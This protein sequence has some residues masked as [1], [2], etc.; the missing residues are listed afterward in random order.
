MNIN[1][2]MNEERTM[3]AVETLSSKQ[4]QLIGVGAAMAAGCEPCTV[5]FVA[6]AKAEG[7]CERGVRFAIESG[8]QGRASATASMAAFA[9]AAFPRP[10]LDAT[11]REE[12]VLLDALIGVAAA[13]A[14]SAAPV[15]TS[16]VDEARALGATDDQLRVAAQIG[17]A[18][19]RGAE[20]ETESRFGALLESGSGPRCCAGSA[21]TDATGAEVAR[22]SPTRL[23]GGGRPP[24]PCGCGAP[25]ETDYE[26]VSIEKTHAACSLCEDYARA[27]S[28]KPVVVMS[29]E[30]ACLRGEISRQAANH[31][32]HSLAPDTTVR[33]CLGGAFTKDA[34]QRGLVRNAA[35]VVALEGCS[36]RCASR[37]MRGHFPHL[38]AEVLVTDGM[39]NFDRSLF[40]IEA[41]PEET[42][43]ELGRSVAA[44]VAG[45]L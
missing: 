31:L 41:L 33:L 37:M 11:F 36:I 38:E 7:A 24:G 30:G 10:E 23:E 26:T 14:S 17:R 35:K 44:K 12:R 13:V 4:K 28:H 25:D 32:C 40:G 20:G 18:A 19:R 16:R 15:L 29:C 1:V 42:V 34:G 39:C 21:D 45:R 2:N 43:R 5:S 6:A 9:D 8:L 27:Q 3:N 22:V